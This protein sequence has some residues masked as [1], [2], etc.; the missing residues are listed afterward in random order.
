MTR[1]LVQDPAVLW[2]LRLG[3]ALLF[4]AAA[5]HKARNFAGFRAALAGYRLLPARWTGAAAA[6]LLLAEVGTGIALLLPGGVRSAALAAALLLG[7][8]SAAIGINLARGR[9]E[10]DCGCGGSGSRRPLSDA[11]IARNA[12]LIAVAGA[13][14]LSPAGRPLVWLDALTVTG[15]AAALALLYTAL[16]AAL[17]NAPRLRELGGGTWSTR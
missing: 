1:A 13:C 7:L 4:L 17:A 6:L 11:L 3:L 12:L 8:Y 14:S 15:G 9:R 10:I 16:D 5:A 2:A